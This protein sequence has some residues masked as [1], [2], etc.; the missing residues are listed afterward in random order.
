ME[1]RVIGGVT[2]KRLTRHSDER[3]FFM[4]LARLRSD[5]FFADPGVAQVSTA[6]RQS[7]VTAWHLHP[8]QVDWWW[9]VEGELQVAVLDRRPDSATYNV[10]DELILGGTTDPDVVLKIPAGVAHGHKVRSG[11]VRLLYLASR[12]YDPKEE[13]RLDPADP[14]LVT[15]YDWS[16]DARR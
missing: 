16:R 13:L 8:T 7:G 6:V 15:L 12:A 2:T 3:G 11:P 10:V 14:E 4:E 9:V 1:R 5:P